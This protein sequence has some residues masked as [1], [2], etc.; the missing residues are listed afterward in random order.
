[1]FSI[2]IA[3]QKNI[4]KN[5]ELDDKY[6]SQKKQSHYEKMKLFTV[7]VFKGRIGVTLI[8]GVRF[9]QTN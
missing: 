8:L 7:L 9:G 1:M 3:T 5:P 2:R 4:S 6:F